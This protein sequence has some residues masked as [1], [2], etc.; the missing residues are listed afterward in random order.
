MHA[1]LSAPER[2]SPEEGGPLFCSSARSQNKGRL[3]AAP[4]RRG[5]DGIGAMAGLVTLS[6]SWLWTAMIIIIII[7]LPSYYHHVSNNEWSITVGG[8]SFACMPS[9]V[10]RGRVTLSSCLHDR[11]SSSSSC[12]QSSH[13]INAMPDRCCIF[14]FLPLQWGAGSMA[15]MLWLDW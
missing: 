6:S 3:P 5:V 4:V 13:S 14:V 2:V 10:C 12:Y 8:D 11:C 15:L 1:T 9:L 7:M